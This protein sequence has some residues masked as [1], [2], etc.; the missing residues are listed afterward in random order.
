MFGV[1]DSA[2]ALEVKIISPVVRGLPF[3]LHAVFIKYLNS[4]LK[5]T[6]KSAP[7]PEFSVSFIH[8]FDKVK[9]GKTRPEY[10]IISGCDFDR[11]RW[12]NRTYL[13]PTP[14]FADVERH[15][16]F[17]IGN[18]SIAVPSV[19]K[20]QV[21]LNTPI[22]TDQKYITRDYTRTMSGE[23]L[24]ARDSVLLF[25]DIGL[26]SSNEHMSFGQGI[27]SPQFRS[28]L[29]LRITQSGS[30]NG[31]TRSNSDQESGNNN[32]TYSKYTNSNSSNRLNSE[33]I[34]F[35]PRI[36][37][38]KEGRI[39]VYGGIILVVVMGGLVSWVWWMSR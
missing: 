5:R 27:S 12:S 18:S 10:V 19:I 6:D 37:R 21:N 16:E 26:R 8:V 31:Q 38:E 2:E 23:E 33:M 28:L 29:L 36:D 13:R 30:S 17:K 15:I 25:Q 9:I 3:P 1:L 20:G 39:I 7:L 4:E 14:F 35:R 34:A 11:Q 24:Q 32:Q 22:S